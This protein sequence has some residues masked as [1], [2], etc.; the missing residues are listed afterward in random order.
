[1]KTCNICD[2]QGFCWSCVY[3]NLDFNKPC[4]TKD[5]NL[6]LKTKTEPKTF[7]EPGLLFIDVF[8]LIQDYDIDKDL[9]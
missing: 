5:N 4:A 7:Y 3:T 6:T 9:L 8:T 1:M 2:A